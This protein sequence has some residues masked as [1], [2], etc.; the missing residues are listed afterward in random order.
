[1]LWIRLCWRRTRIV[2][3]MYVIAESAQQNK[4][5]VG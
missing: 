1:M 5:Y 2:P 4:K 3:C